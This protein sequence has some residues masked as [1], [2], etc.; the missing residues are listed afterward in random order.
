VSPFFFEKSKESSQQP[1][2]NVPADESQRTCPVCGD[3]F[4][5]VWDEANEEW[6]F[7]GVTDE[8]GEYVHQRCIASEGS[9]PASPPPR[10]AAK[11]ESSMSEEEPTLPLAS[12]VK[13]QPSEQTN[14]R[15]SKSVEQSFAD[16]KPAEHE[17]DEF[18]A[19]EHDEFEPQIKREHEGDEHQAKRQR[20]EE[21]SE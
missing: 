10:R 3:E 7:K 17:H 4:E 14:E 19:P 20:V 1:E 18:E 13:L 5:Q 6:M 21:Q 8:S 9:P 11:K 2:S 12:L 15:A 16:V